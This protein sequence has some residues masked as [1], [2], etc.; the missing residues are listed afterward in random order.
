MD[1]KKLNTSKNTINENDLANSVKP[2][3]TNPEKSRSKKKDFINV[4]INDDISKAELI[5]TATYDELMQLLDEKTLG[6]VVKENAKRILFNEFKDCLLEKKNAIVPCFYLSISPTGGVN[7]T[8]KMA[9]GGFSYKLERKNGLVQ[10]NLKNSSKIT[11]EKWDVLAESTSYDYLYARDNTVENNC[12]YTYRL[13]VKNLING[14]SEVFEKSILFEKMVVEEFSASLDHVRKRVAIHCDVKNAS[15]IKITRKD[16]TKTGAESSNSTENN[17]AVEIIHTD[18]TKMSC[19]PYYDEDV[20]AGKKYQYILDVVDKSLKV[21]A[22]S[23][24][25][26]DCTNVLPRIEGLK[27]RDVTYDNHKVYLDW[28]VPF[29]TT[30]ITVKRKKV[31]ED[32][33]KWVCFVRDS[34]SIEC[35]VHTVCDSDQMSVT[36]SSDTL[37]EYKVTCSNVWGECSGVVEVKT[38]P[39]PE[40]IRLLP[41]EFSPEKNG[42]ICSLKWLGLENIMEYKIT[43]TDCNRKKVDLIRKLDGSANSFDF[44]IYKNTLYT[45]EIKASNAWGSS[46]KILDIKRNEIELVGQEDVNRYR[47][48]GQ[49][50]NDENFSLNFQ[51]ITTDGTWWYL[52]NGVPGHE[53]VNPPTLRRSE[54]NKSLDRDVGGGCEFL[55]AE[56]VHVGDLDCYDDY[57]FVAVYKTNDYTEDA[58]NKDKKHYY[59]QIWIFNK[60]TMKRVITCYLYEPDNV[61]HVYG[62]AWCAVNPF[63]KRLYT[64]SSYIYDQIISYEINFKNIKR[65]ENGEKNLEVFSSPQI[66]RLHGIDGTNGK[67]GIDGIS[68]TK[69]SMQGGCFDYYGN[70][71]LTSGYK[72]PAKLN[73]GIHVLKLIF[74]EDTAL[75]NVLSKAVDD[76]DRVKKYESFISG[77]CEKSYSFTDAVLVAQSENPYY[78]QKGLYLA[79][80][81]GTVIRKDLN[82]EFIY[83][84]NVLKEEEPEGIAYCDFRY[85]PLSPEKQKHVKDGSLHASLLINSDSAIEEKMLLKHYEHKYQETEEL[86]YHYDNNHLSQVGGK[87]YDGNILVKKFETGNS[88]Y[89][90]EL[91]RASK[92]I[93]ECFNKVHTIGWL[94]TSSPNHDYGFTV[95]TAHVKPLNIQNDIL[96]K[97]KRVVAYNPAQFVDGATGRLCGYL[98]SQERYDI[99]LIA[100]DGTEYHFYAHN[101]G[102]AV[103]ICSLLN[104][105]KS[106]CYIGVGPDISEPD[107]GRIRSANNLIWLEC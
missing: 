25:Y 87:I 21:T 4:S 52:T 81:W 99:K 28:K 2:K 13:T 91:A 79:G 17:N 57:L 37:Y 103:S 106:L 54:V 39:P 69:E 100:N 66:V 73:Q 20:V 32:D 55:D 40:R 10:K 53:I 36:L 5:Q 7:C 93:L 98:E 34:S 101:E 82:S 59:G 84:F 19:F 45:Y 65:I 77:D 86:I 11:I 42:F 72:D 78:H 30:N 9:Q 24:C 1:V 96:D 18:S 64:S 62:I 90:V 48:I 85:T 83:Q 8:L 33:S 76:E 6:T 23:L 95:F 61:T 3:P 68:F 107:I 15:S 105:Y 26:A 97:F 51:G 56:H 92:I 63:D 16:I 80:V 47:Y 94:H 38:P 43:R 35:Y 89:D 27:S 12:C 14:T 58:N 60:N 102:D 71:Y 44:H 75:Q 104:G 50:E 49:N 70:L 67:D 41:P 46:V 31:E 29:P 88:D 74:D 22:R